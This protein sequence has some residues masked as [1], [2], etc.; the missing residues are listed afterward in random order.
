M[1]LVRKAGGCPVPMGKRL[2]AAEA[3][4]LRV[5]AMKDRVGSTRA[6]AR[7]AFGFVLEKTTRAEILAWAESAGATCA[8]DPSSVGLDCASAAL[9]KLPSPPKVAEFVPTGRLLFGF[10]SSNVLVSLQLA[11]RATSA[12]D[13]ALAVAAA[14]EVFERD[15]GK[16]TKVDGAPTAEVLAKGALAQVRAE[17]R[18]LNYWALAAATNSAQAFPV[19]L[20]VQ[21]LP[22]PV[23]TAVT[24]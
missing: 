23:E 14:M 15:A 8:P 18:F 4:S 22:E 5:D 10:N 12:S 16:A 19:D 1:G 6:L 24:R 13:A 9:G 7:P 3:E 17:Y 11:A 20:Q 2:T 21:S